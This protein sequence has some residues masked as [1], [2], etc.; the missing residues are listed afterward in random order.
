[1][2]CGCVGGWKGGVGR[3]SS[4]FLGLGWNSQG[5][6]PEASSPVFQLPFPMRG[7]PSLKEEAKPWPSAWSSGTVYGG[8]LGACGSPPPA[9]S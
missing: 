4:G 5:G 1:M 6:G 2:G 9:G 3:S 8:S 7:V